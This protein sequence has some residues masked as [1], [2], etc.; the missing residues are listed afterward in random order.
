[1]INLV[2]RDQMAPKIILSSPNSIRMV[3]YDLEILL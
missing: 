1:M 3:S 2:D